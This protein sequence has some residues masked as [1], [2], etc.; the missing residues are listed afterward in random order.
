MVNTVV[1]DTQNNDVGWRPW[2]QQPWKS[3]DDEDITYDNIRMHITVGIRTVCI[4]Q[5]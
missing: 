4:E 2:R 3:D 5:I 1:M